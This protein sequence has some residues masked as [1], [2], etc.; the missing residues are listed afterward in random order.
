VDGIVLC[1]AIECVEATEANHGLL[2]AEL[3]HGTCVEFGDTTLVGV[4]HMVQAGDLADTLTA[5]PTLA[6]V[7][8]VARITSIRTPGVASGPA[9]SASSR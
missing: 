1:Q 8:D 3:V 5:P 2:G 7:V 9:A 4:C 6:A